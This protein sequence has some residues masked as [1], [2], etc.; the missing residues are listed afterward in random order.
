MGSGEII[1][2]EFLGDGKLAAGGLDLLMATHGSYNI[3][4]R[5]CQSKLIERTQNPNSYQPKVWSFS[6]DLK[7]PKL[8]ISVQDEMGLEPLR[9][10]ELDECDQ[11]IWKRPVLRLIIGNADTATDKFRAMGENKIDNS[12]VYHI[13]S[14]TI[15]HCNHINFER[16]THHPPLLSPFTPPTKYFSSLQSWSVFS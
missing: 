1:S 6:K 9:E 3:T 15:N 11:D 14:V 8:R 4:I 10:I 5:N 16:N 7:T 13:Y 12:F 2:L